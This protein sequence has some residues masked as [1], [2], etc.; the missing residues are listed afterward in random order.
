[1]SHVR[2]LGFDALEDRKL[3]SRSHV[4]APHT[5]PMVVATPV[6][7]DGTLAVDNSAAASTS[8]PDGST[9]TSTPVA[10]RLG[11]LGKVRGVW[12]QT[13]DEFGDLDGPNVLRLA[14]PKGSLIVTFNT[15][16]AIKAHPTGHGDFYYPRAQQV[17]EGTGAYAGAVETGMIDLTTN[18]SKSE[19]TSLVLSTANS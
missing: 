12:N 6:V 19:I 16:T 14:V 9:T 8:N 5:T 10:G 11:A 7:L 18:H 3:L 13:V 2:A 17:L 15:L 4:A 1:M